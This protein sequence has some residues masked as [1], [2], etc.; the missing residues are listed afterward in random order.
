MSSSSCNSASH[1]NCTL[2]VTWL[3]KHSDCDVLASPTTA[4]MPVP[5]LTPFNCNT[6]KTPSPQH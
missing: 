4:A 5:F 1:E 6:R 3:Y 2:Q